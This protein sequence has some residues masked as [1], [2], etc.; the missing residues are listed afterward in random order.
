M[1]GFKYTRQG[2]NVGL[3]YYQAPDIA[4]EEPDE[5]ARRARRSYEAVIRSS[6]KHRRHSTSAG[7]SDSPSQ[8]ERLNS[9]VKNFRD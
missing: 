9:P 6:S 8:C 3:S 1:A 2:N 5:A 4:L 7:A